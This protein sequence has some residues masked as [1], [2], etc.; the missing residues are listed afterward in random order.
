[1]NTILNAKIKLPFNIT[2]SFNVSPRYQWFYDRYFSSK[3]LP[4]LDPNNPW[5]Q[6]RTNKDVSTG[7]LITPLPGT[8]GS[9]KDHHV[10]VTLVQEA[11]DRREWKRSY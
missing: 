11:E 7:R 5:R 9:I 4:G 8:S 6:P 10:V 1:M 2:Y 3:E